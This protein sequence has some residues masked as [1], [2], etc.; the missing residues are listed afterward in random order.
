MEI[1]IMFPYIYIYN[2]CLYGEF[3]IFRQTAIS[4]F[5]DGNPVGSSCPTWQDASELHSACTEPSS[6]QTPG[7]LMEKI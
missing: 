1:I 3:P 7:W 6:I 4:Y 5:L 2:V